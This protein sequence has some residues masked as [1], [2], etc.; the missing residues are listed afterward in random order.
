MEELRLIVGDNIYILT[1]D[2][3]LKS[4]FLSEIFSGKY[5]E[6]NEVNL[7]LESELEEAFDYIYNK[8]INERYHIGVNIKTFMN[9]IFLADYMYIDEIINNFARIILEGSILIENLLNYHYIYE[10]ITKINESVALLIIKTNYDYNKLPDW[11]MDIFNKYETKHL[12]YDVIEPVI[13]IKLEPITLDFTNDSNPIYKHQTK[14]KFKASN[15]NFDVYIDNRFCGN[16]IYA[17]DVKKISTLNAIEILNIV[18]IK[19]LRKYL[20]IE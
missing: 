13:L 14:Q 10:H 18:N 1:H 11:V 4:K 3:I 15:G 2:L 17:Y 16:Y 19:G 5:K 20:P 8:L 12:I 9:I 6:T 7:H